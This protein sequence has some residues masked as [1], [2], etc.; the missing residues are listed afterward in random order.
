MS[1]I[2]PVSSQCPNLL[3]SDSQGSIPKLKDAAPGK[4]REASSPS[5]SASR[6]GDCSTTQ[7]LSSYIL[8]PSAPFPVQSADRGSLPTS[9][10]DKAR[11]R[12]LTIPVVDG[13][14]GSAI[15]SGESRRDSRGVSDE[16][17]GGHIRAAAEP[18]RSMV[19]VDMDTTITRQTKEE[20]GALSDDT[21]SRPSMSPREESPVTTVTA[22]R[23]RDAEA[24]DSARV[25]EQDVT[26]RYAA[27]ADRVVNKSP[28]HRRGDTLESNRE[29]EE[30]ALRNVDRRDSRIS[31]GGCRSSISS[32]CSGSIGAPDVDEFI[33]PTISFASRTRKL[34][35]DL[36]SG[37]GVEKAAAALA[38]VPTAAKAAKMAMSGCRPIIPGVPPGAI[39]DDAETSAGED[40]PVEVVVRD[41][42]E[43]VYSFK[44]SGRPRRGKWSRLEEEFAKR[45]VGCVTF[46]QGG[47]YMLSYGLI[48]MLQTCAWWE[49]QNKASVFRRASRL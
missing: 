22:S 35:E 32:S 37:S 20:G 29:S 36:S 40:C 34:G 16:R 47:D 25:P 1:T 30:N 44:K 42:G 43:V 9:P 21:E 6:R 11:R 2:V 5:D 27:C 24:A 49:S 26:Q 13:F 12:R 10:S 31:S 38:A 18:D 45:L 15:A 7:R 41:S 4:I 23:R 48:L 17:H 28:P 33:F 14:D 8:N 19:K 3:G 39:V 46:F